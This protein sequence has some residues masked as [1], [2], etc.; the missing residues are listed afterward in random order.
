M[1]HDQKPKITLSE[2]LSLLIEFGDTNIRLCNAKSG[3][4]LTY[5]EYD[6]DYDNCL[7]DRMYVTDNTI[8]VYLII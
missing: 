7:I 5:N 1:E 4:T 3:C 6:R 2:F 8:T